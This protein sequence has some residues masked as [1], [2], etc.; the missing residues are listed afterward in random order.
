[1]RVDAPF[2]AEP[3][4]LDGQRSIELVNIYQRALSDKEKRRL[5]RNLSWFGN[6]RQERLAEIEQGLAD[7]YEFEI[8]R[9]W[10]INGC[11][12]PCCPYTLLFETT[13]DSFVYIESWDEVEREE[14]AKAE[15]RLVIE[16]T[17]GT[18]RLFK[19][20][21]EGQLRTKHNEQLRDLNEFFEIDGGAEWRTFEREEMPTEVMA[22][23]E[24]V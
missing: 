17:P 1:V 20:I 18:K 4:S 7:V 5:K 23:L 6:H 16:S 3:R 8:N 11:R 10:D 12:P 19:S 24:A 21:I 2:A 13:G 9:V 15:M 22:I 14:S